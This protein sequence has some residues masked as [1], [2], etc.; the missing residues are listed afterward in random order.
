MTQSTWT[1]AAIIGGMLCSQVAMAQTAPAP[2]LLHLSATGTVQVTPDQLVADMLA[3]NT[4]RSPAAAQRLVNSMIAT[5]MS[6]STAVAGVEARA[7][8]YSVGPLDDKRTGWTAQQT[9]ELRSSE[10]PAL[11]DLVGKL[12]QQGLAAGS[13][14]WEVSPAL[15]R[16]AHEQAT[17]EALK[18][19]QARAASAAEAL[20]LHLDHIQ[21]V[22]LDSTSV[23]PRAFPA[24]AMARMA[25]PAPQATASQEDVTASVS[26]DYVLKP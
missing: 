3:L 10:G 5:G 1:V 12:Q 14:D 7:V 8:G 2:M 19:L 4:A 13:L 26:A 21:D 6:T 18:S 11:L 15:R 16:K 20:G 23:P 17:T 9:L 22:R 25:A 24:M